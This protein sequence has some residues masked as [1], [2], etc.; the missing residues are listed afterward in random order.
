VLLQTNQSTKTI[1]A[2]SRTWLA[3]NELAVPSRIWLLVF[4]QTKNHQ[5]RFHIKS[6]GGTNNWGEELSIWECEGDENLGDERGEESLWQVDAPDAY[7][8]RMR[9]VAARSFYSIARGEFGFERYWSMILAKSAL[10]TVE[11]R[12]SVA[13]GHRHHAAFGLNSEGIQCLPHA[14]SDWQTGSPEWVAF[15]GRRRGIPALAGVA[16][17][18]TVFAIPRWQSGEEDNAFPVAGPIDWFTCKVLTAA[19]VSDLKGFVLCSLWA[20]WPSS[21]LGLMYG[22]LIGEIGK[23]TV[24]L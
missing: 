8:Y 6:R 13:W 10:R 4:S 5:W 12:L 21:P 11:H 22:T 2:P 24:G 3:R 17:A 16:I 15:D 18:M 9:D 14:D 7:G 23:S 20:W 19:D 1:T